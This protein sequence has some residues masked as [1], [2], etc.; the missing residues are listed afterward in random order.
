MLFRSLEN[1]CKIGTRRLFAGNL[2]RHPAYKKL[3]EGAYRVSGNLTN[4]DRIMN[5]VFW[6]GVHPSLDRSCMNYIFECIYKF[7]KGES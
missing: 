4:T 2:L 5:N 6:V 3:P 1:D 7:Y